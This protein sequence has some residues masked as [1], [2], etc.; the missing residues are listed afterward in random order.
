MWRD[1][2][3]Q[4]GDAIEPR[5][6]V[7]SSDCNVSPSILTR[8][9]PP[10]KKKKKRESVWIELFILVMPMGYF[11]LST[12][13]KKKKKKNRWDLAPK[14]L[15][16]PACSH[17]YWEPSTLFSAQQQSPVRNNTKPLEQNSK[18]P[19]KKVNSVFLFYFIFIW[20][21]DHCQL[22]HKGCLQP[23]QKKKKKTRELGKVLVNE[24]LDFF[25]LILKFALSMCPRFGAQ[26]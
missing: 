15:I 3:G 1:R 25:M 7:H 10:P 23:I 21:N 9:L 4:V 19:K 12:S 20:S 14:L 13:E 5:L 17:I 11:M 2:F 22:G 26:H 6:V 16:R 24:S 8:S 18:D